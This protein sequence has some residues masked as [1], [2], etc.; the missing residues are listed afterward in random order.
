VTQHLP[1]TATVKILVT[2]ALEIEEPDWCAG[3]GEAVAQ[4]K[5]DVT[6]YGPE[7]VI[8]SYGHEV[9]HAMLAQSPFSEV[10][11][12]DLALFVETGDFT[13][14]YSPAEVAELADALEAAAGQ[15]RA[16]GRQLAR[17]LPGGDR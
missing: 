14:A 15:L 16:L 4:F 8:G 12:P 1:R 7:H 9:L 17:L 13:G 11:S 6:H 5:P 3:H 10:A 2:K